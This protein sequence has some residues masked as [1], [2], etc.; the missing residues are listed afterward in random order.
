MKSKIGTIAAFAAG[1]LISVS[2]TLFASSVTLPFSFTAGSL[3]R[4]SDMN[5]N[6]AAVKTAVDDNHARLTT[7]EN[8][9]SGAVSVSIHGF[10]EFF[11]LGVCVLQRNQ[12]MLYFQNSGV[13][14]IATAQISLPHG[15][16]VQNLSCLVYDNSATGNI[17]PASL[18]RVNLS[19]G[20]VQ[21]VITTNQ[22]ST[23]AGL[24]TL[25]ANTFLAS[26]VV[27]NNAFAYYL[28]VAFDTTGLSPATDLRLHGCK[29][30]YQS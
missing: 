6:F 18:T 1:I 25:T 24:Q 5:A 27:D 20:V 9:L 17:Y 21:S 19:T 14:C 10:T 26:A 4:A 29:V 8:K 7:L 12:N 23:N 16:T 3:V 30:G 11:N 2:A 15:S 28:E 13:G 22:T